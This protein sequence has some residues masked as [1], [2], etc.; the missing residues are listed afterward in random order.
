ML[1]TKE[2]LL[3]IR[4]LKQEKY[5]TMLDIHFLR[6]QMK[7]IK[8]RVEYLKRQIKRNEVILQSLTGFPN[9]KKKMRLFVPL[10][11]IILSLLSLLDYS[12][13]N[14]TKIIWL[15]SLYSAG[16]LTTYFLFL[17][18]EKKTFKGYSEEPLKDLIDDQKQ[19]LKSKVE[20]LGYKQDLKETLSCQ[21]NLYS[22]EIAKLSVGVP[23]LNIV[24]QHHQ[25]VLPINDS[26]ID[27]GQMYSL[28]R[29]KHK[30]SISR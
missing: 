7:E 28:K 23:N 25:E 10:F 22:D 30:T 2:N 1:T 11:V 19:E 8:E 20:D 15:F 13:I 4:D 27:L 18:Q 24:S 21:K 17:Y 14:I 12:S 29:K 3:R 16:G 5:Q 26:S 9:F 6:P